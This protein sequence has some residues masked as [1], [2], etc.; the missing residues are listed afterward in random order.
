MLEL[1]LIV[2]LLICGA[3]LGGVA[4]ASSGIPMLGLLLAVIGGFAG[5]ILAYIILYYAKRR[6][7]RTK[8]ALPRTTAQ[9][10]VG[11]RVPFSKRMANFLKIEE[12]ELLRSDSHKSSMPFW[13]LLDVYWRRTTRTAQ[14]LR[15]ILLRIRKHLR[16]SE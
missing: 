12:P 4:G 14:E 11:T 16:S 10:P 6:T 1:A 7:L 15:T 9:P 13:S 3:G 5:A 2:L 8:A